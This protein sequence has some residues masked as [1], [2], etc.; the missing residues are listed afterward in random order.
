[1]LQTDHVRGGHD[2]SDHL[3]LALRK[4][5]P[6]S[7]L[8][9][10]SVAGYSTMVWECRHAVDSPV[11]SIGGGLFE[12]NHAGYFEVLAV[13][14]L[15]GLFRDPLSDFCPRFYLSIHHLTASP[16]TSN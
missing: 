13:I 3:A 14:I 15:S 11:T 9:H 2:W 16:N 6:L 8:S 7:R 5:E 10:S 1:S 12:R 4:I